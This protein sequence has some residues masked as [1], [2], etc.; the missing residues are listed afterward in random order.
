MALG[1]RMAHSV[2]EETFTNW[3]FSDNATRVN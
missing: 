2:S 3:A 1:S